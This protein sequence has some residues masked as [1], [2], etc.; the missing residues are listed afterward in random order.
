MCLLTKFHI[1][2]PFIDEIFVYLIKNTNIN[3]NYVDCDNNNILILATWRNF[4][5]IDLILKHS[6]LS[7]NFQNIH[8]QT[9]LHHRDSLQNLSRIKKCVNR[10]NFDIYLK[11]AN[12]KTIFDLA[13]EFNYPKTINYLE[14]LINKTNNYNELNFLEN[15]FISILFLM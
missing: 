1:N 2:D 11:D 6:K 3:L 10:Y 9:L 4:D 13:K 14:T 12:G 5:F 8:G 7:I 15:S